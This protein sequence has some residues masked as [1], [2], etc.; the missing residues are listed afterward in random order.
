MVTDMALPILKG[1]RLGAQAGHSSSMY[2]AYEPKPL[3]WRC[4]KTCLLCKLRFVGCVIDEG[5][6]TG[7]NIIS[8]MLQGIDPYL[9]TTILID[10]HF[11]NNT[12]TPLCIFE[13]GE[14]FN[15]KKLRIKQIHKDFMEEVQSSFSLYPIKK[16]NNGR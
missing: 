3:S 16:K 2:I 15:K 14:S 12:P 11:L 9:T 13:F 6:V 10:N 4:L 7:K 5:S 1:A 8:F